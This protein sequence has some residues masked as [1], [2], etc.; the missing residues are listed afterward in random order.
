[1]NAKCEESEEYEIPLMLPFVNAR[2]PDCA[3]MLSCLRCHLVLKCLLH[4]LYI[5]ISTI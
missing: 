2:L 1:M 4:I 5:C 3:G